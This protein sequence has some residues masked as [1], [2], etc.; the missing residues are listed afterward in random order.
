MGKHKTRHDARAARHPACRVDV[1]TV[2]DDPTVPQHTCIG[3]NSHTG[4]VAE[5]MQCIENT[6]VITSTRTYAQCCSGHA[7]CESTPLA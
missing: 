6:K 3:C 2:D 4:G 1:S 5:T 7:P